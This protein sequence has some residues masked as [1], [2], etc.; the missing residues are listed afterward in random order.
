MRD[1]IVLALI[2]S[3]L[4]VSSC[5]DC[6]VRPAEAQTV[7]A[8]L[9]AGGSRE[10]AAVTVSARL[11]C[12]E[13]DGHVADYGAI[14]HTLQ[15]RADRHGLSLVAMARAYSAPL[16]GHGGARGR[17][18]RALPVLPTPGY[19]RTWRGCVDAAQAFVAGELADP[20]AG[21]STHFGSR[22]DVAS[23]WPGVAEIDCGAT[24]N[25]FFAEVAR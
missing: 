25:V 20:C 2:V 4:S 8:R 22:R 11:L 13:A 17:W 3:A 12:G 14:L 10:A 15:R 21:P 9:A 7:P 24:R 18:V 6:G 1:E 23:R 16:R 5:I 19:A